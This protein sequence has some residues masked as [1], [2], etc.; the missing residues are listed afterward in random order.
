MSRDT[1]Y[2][3][4]VFDVWYEGPGLMKVNDQAGFPPDEGL[5]PV[6]VVFPKKLTGEEKI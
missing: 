3:K 6:T 4:N 5:T 1:E 2:C